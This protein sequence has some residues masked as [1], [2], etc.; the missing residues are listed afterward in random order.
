M[1]RCDVD[2]T[3]ELAPFMV[4]QSQIG[5]NLSRVRDQIKNTCVNVGRNEDEVTLV[6]VSKK[7]SS[8]NILV[9]YQCGQRHFGESYI[10]EAQSKM[11]A[12]PKD[13][14]WHCV[15][16]MQHNK[17]NKIIHPF[18]LIQSVD[19][20]ALLK[21]SSFQHQKVLVQVKLVNETQ[22]SGVLEGELPRFL[23]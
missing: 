8:E 15:G 4:F 17:T 23:E 12:L 16:H 3:S 11:S 10:Q 18:Y 22:K 7:V 9:T 2:A 5:S 6:A 1:G 21:S 20:L 19:D 14:R 13:I